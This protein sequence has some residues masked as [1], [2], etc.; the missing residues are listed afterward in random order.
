MGVQQLSSVFGEQVNPTSQRRVRHSPGETE[1]DYSTVTGGE[2]SVEPRPPSR[3]DAALSP[4]ESH[5]VI[6]QICQLIGQGLEDQEIL[7]R[8]EMN[9]TPSITEV[10]AYLRTR[11]DLRAGLLSDWE[12]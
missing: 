12:I 4:H 3:V 5:V 1:A 8:I 11:D 9:A 10:I 6:R 2:S 7:D